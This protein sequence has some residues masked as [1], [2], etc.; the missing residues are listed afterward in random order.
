MLLTWHNLTFYQDV[1]AGLC[2]AIADGAVAEFAAATLDRM[3]A[4]QTAS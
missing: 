4:D 3:Q 1:M 2:A